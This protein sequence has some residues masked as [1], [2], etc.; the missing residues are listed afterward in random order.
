MIMKKIFC[1][2]LAIMMLLVLCACDGQNDNSTT[3]TVPTTGNNDGKPVG[4][5]FTSDNGTQ[6][7]VKMP[8]AGLIDKLGE[9]RSKETS[10][11]CAF[12]GLDTVYKYDSFWI[13]ANDEGGYEM[14]YEITLTDDLVKTEEGICIGASAADVTAKYGASEGSSD[15]LLVYSKDGM[16]LM[17]VITNGAVTKIRYTML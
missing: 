4:Y 9:P 8:M 7:G 10:E 3:T 2:L 5:L 14:I 6:F 11:S 16:K 13:S 17:F 1:M 12:A 15:A